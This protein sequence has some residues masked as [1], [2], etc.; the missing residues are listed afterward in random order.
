MLDQVTGNVGAKLASSQLQVYLNLSRDTDQSTFV[1][2]LVIV[3]LKQHV[4]NI[5]YK[6]IIYIANN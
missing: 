2:I 6:V 3:C 4:I 1:K 5:L